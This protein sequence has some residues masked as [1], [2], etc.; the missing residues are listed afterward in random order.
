MNATQAPD[1][2]D[3]YILT[4]FHEYAGRAWTLF[5]DRYADFIL[6]HLLRIGFDY[7]Q[8]MDRFVYVCEKLC[9]DDFRRLKSVR[10]AGSRGELVPWLRT[11]VNNLCVNWICSTEGRKRLLKPI[12]RLPELEQQIFQLYFWKA[13]TP[14]EISEYLRLSGSS[15]L[16]VGDI[17]EAL[18]RIFACL[19]TKKLWRL[20]SNLARRRGTVSLD[21]VDEDAG[22]RLDVADERPNPEQLLLARETDAVLRRALDSLLASERLII[23]LR[24]EE[25]MELNDIAKVLGVS[26]SEVK[27]WLKSGLARLNQALRE[28]DSRG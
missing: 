2:T 20:L 27:R 22:T 28:L 7:D 15:T 14:S 17:L 8:A 25:R 21:E 11:V 24:Y 26:A 6:T 4:L 10:Y 5:V 1:S 9:E 13:L 16:E 18:E 19:S 3:H 12:A 23:Q